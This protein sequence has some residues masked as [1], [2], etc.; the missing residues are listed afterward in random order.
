MPKKSLAYL[1]KIKLKNAPKNPGNL[2]DIWEKG[3]N[4]EP[5]DLVGATQGAVLDD[6]DWFANGQEEGQLGVD[7]YQK[8]SKI[9]IK[10][11]VGGVKPNDL[12]ISLQNDLLTIRGKREK[13]EQITE[14]DYLYKECYW[15]KFSRSVVLPVE[16]D[17]NGVEAS[18]KSGV[19]TLTVPVAKQS[20]VAK[21]EVVDQGD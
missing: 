20:K 14:K 13:E 9:V 11:I 21:V 17:P 12:D 2:L 5:D 7:V 19:L 10:A 18:L 1:Q 8:D 3:F 4:I 6:D 16:V 15:G